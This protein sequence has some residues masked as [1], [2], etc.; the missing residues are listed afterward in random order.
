MTSVAVAAAAAAEALTLL[1]QLGVVVL[2]EKVNASA[3]NR[4]G[5]SNFNEVCKRYCII[6]V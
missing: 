4:K 2:V 5:L 6:C 1:L 3:N